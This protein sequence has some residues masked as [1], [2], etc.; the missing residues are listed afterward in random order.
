MA[1]GTPLTICNSTV[2]LITSIQCTACGPQGWNSGL[3]SKPSTGEFASSFY[4]DFG[5]D[6]DAGISGINNLLSQLTGGPSNGFIINR[7]EFPNGDT[8]E[9]ASFGLAY[10]G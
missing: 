2:G 1:P 3:T 8:G 7:G 5:V 10:P 6:P 9:M 4:V